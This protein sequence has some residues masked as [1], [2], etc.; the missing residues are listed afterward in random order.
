MKKIIP[1]FITL[2]TNSL[3][4]QNMKI[5]NP[6]KEEI[7]IVI[8]DSTTISSLVSTFH[9]KKD[10]LKFK[11]W[12]SKT[13]V[14]D[15]HRIIIEFFDKQGALINN[16][17]DFNS[18]NEVRFVK[19]QI[20]NLKKN[21]SYKIKL[22]YEQGIKFLRN[23]TPKKL[24]LFK[25]DLPKYFDFNV[26]ELKNNQILFLDKSEKDKCVIIYPDLKTLASENTTIAEQYYASDDDEHIM[27][28][29]AGGDALTDYNP[30][31]HLVYPKYIDDII[32]NHKLE[33]IEQKVY[34]KEFYGN[35]YKSKKNGL[36]FL[37]DE[38]NQENGAGNIMQILEVNIFENLYDVRNAQKDYIKFKNE[39]SSPEYFYQRISDQYGKD[40]PKYITQ[41]IDRLPETLNIER[42]N[43]TLD[44]TGLEIL[45]EAIMWNHENIQLFNQ[46]FPSVIAFYG[47]YYIQNKKDG[48]WITVF[49]KES[50]LWIPKLQLNDGS[51][52]WDA[53]ELYK[54]LYEGSV[55]L[56]WLEEPRR[57]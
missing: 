37:I 38:I 22:N 40:F 54:G 16:E 18:L 27:K 8:I 46:W 23:E 34:I 49:D 10:P 29:L 15:D 17:K 21:I 13:Y 47:Q 5:I 3:L 1:F 28:K 32:K 2:I 6:I 30:N 14:L 33:L 43:L 12:T 50:N 44:E 41:L 57:R 24:S 36:Y 19:N 53:G 42:E 55:R 4:S 11:D 45:D 52:A 26:Y 56:K 48:K 51:F 39:L 25:S 7:N 9:G 20:W 35:L 31:E